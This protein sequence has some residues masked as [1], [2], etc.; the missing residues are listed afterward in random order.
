MPFVTKVENIHRQTTE[1]REEFM[2]IT[3]AGALGDE[4]VGFPLL[5]GGYDPV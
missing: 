5:L 3:A 4:T 1:P 2:P